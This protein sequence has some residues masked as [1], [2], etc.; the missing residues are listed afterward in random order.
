MAAAA[1]Y[2]VQVTTP[3]GLPLDVLAEQPGRAVEAVRKIDHALAAVRPTLFAYQ[4]IFHLR[5]RDPDI[6]EAV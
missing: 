1:G 2:T 4:F 6:V 5:P 3:V